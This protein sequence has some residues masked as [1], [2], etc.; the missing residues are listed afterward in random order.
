MSWV[1]GAQKIINFTQCYVIGSITFGFTRAVTYDHESTKCY[2]NS[3]TLRHEEKRMLLV[4]NLSMITSKTFASM[5]YWPTM[6]KKDLQRLECFC[7]GKSIDEFK[8]IE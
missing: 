5:F 4:D 7:T 2:F 3:C 1:L 8:I 6:L